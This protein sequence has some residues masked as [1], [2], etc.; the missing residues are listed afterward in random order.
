MCQIE[1]QMLQRGMTFVHYP[2]GII[3][4]SQR[5]RAHA[6]SSMTTAIYLRGP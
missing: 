3:L 6:A 1:G 4:M 5:E 2:H